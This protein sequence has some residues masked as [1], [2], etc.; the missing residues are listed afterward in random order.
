MKKIEMT[1]AF[2]VQNGQVLLPLKKRKIG[3]GKHHGVGGKLDEGETHEQAMVRECI[4]EVGLQPTEY[5]YMAELSFNQIVN[6]ERRVSIIH[7]YLVHSWKGTLKET[8]EMKPYW[9][10]LNNIPY[11]KTMDDSKYWF[12]PVLEG[13]KII[14]DFELDNNYITLNHDI[15]EVKTCKPNRK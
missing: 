3:K 6:G 9:F 15:K 10:D 7:A 8:D 11:D 1:E 12:P 4:E 13:K 5:E 2:F 14:A